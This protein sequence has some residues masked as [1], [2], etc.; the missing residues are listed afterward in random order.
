MCIYVYVQIGRRVL[1]HSRL[2]HMFRRHLS[3]LSIYTRKST[4]M[5]TYDIHLP[6]YTANIQ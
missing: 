3:F 2:K 6:M 4:C 5:H 1:E